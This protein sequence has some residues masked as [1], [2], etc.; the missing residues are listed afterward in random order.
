MT[1]LSSLLVYAHMAVP[2]AL[3]RSPYREAEP[4]TKL[5]VYYAGQS[6][7]R[8]Q[9]LKHVF[10]E[11]ATIK[12]ESYKKIEP[13]DEETRHVAG[14]KVMEAGPQVPTAQPKERIAVISGDTLVKTPTL[15]PTEYG[16]GEHIRYI[17]QGKVPDAAVV[18]AIF[19]KMV[20]THAQTGEG[21]VY[22]IEASSRAEI[23]HPKGKPHEGVSD[24]NHHIIQLDT[25]KIKSLGNG[26]FK[27]Y[28][29]ACREFH[30]GHVY[31]PTGDYVRQRGKPMDVTDISGGL[32][33]PVLTKLG[34]VR[35]INGIDR[36]D[37]E[38]PK[39]LHEAI[40][41]ATVG[42]SKVVLNHIE[43]GS[44]ETVHSYPWVKNIVTYALVPK[45]R[46]AA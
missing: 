37:P 46:F 13:T 11:V 26:G 42:I 33:L 27:E 21:L 6:P 30:N 45:D 2:P 18:Q 12:I 7:R 20:E 5:R 31:D 40:F 10:G 44:G 24:M 19:Q 9:F 1:I 3:E 41:S 16:V 23:R 4:P 8:A 32:E 29:E 25:E 43:P 15:T 36:S 22:Y 14:W 35:G 34:A 17:R 39:A 28:I 38:F